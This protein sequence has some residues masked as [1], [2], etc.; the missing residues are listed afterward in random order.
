[1]KVVFIWWTAVVIVGLVAMLLI[2][3]AGR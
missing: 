3:L 2:S 1:M